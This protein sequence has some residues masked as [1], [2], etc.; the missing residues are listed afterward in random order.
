MSR[1]RVII[2]AVLTLG[3]LA[4]L[5]GFGSYYLWTTGHGF[6]FW[7]VMAACMSAGYLLGWYWQRKR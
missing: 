3:P 4:V 1:W 6:A 2:V 5:A 7:W